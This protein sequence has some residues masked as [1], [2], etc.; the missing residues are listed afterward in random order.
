[1]RKLFLGVLFLSSVWVLSFA[2]EPKFKRAAISG[3][4]KT[5]QGHGLS[6]VLVRLINTDRS[7]SVSVLSQAGGRYYA[8][9]LFPGNYEVRAERKGYQSAVKGGVRADGPTSIDLV[10]RKVANEDSYL[11]SEHVFNQFPEDPDKDLVVD[12]CF[13]CHSMLSF[14]KERKSHD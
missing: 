2:S 8:D 7:I 3:T 11:S 5:T 4:V 12:T 6:G 1:M 10:V 9:A 13:R 14:L